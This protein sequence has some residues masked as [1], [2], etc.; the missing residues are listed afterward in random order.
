M[1]RR[2]FLATGAVST[3][4]M[5]FFPG[6]LLAEEAKSNNKL[7][8]PLPFKMDGEWKEFELYIDIHVHE[9]APGFK[10]H[11]L[12]F[13]D[14][15]PGPEIRVNAGDKVRVKF[16]NKTDLN[17]TIHWHGMHVPWRM[18]GV[19]FVTQL[20]VMPKNE[21][22]YEFEAQPEGTH[23]YHCHWGTLMHMQA[24]MFG[25]LIVEN[26]NDPI[27]KKFSYEREYTLVYS[28]HDTNYVRGEMNGMLERMKQQSFLM[29]EG[30]FTPEEWSVFDSKEQLQE[31]MSNGFI[32]PY[33]N[34]RRSMPDLPQANWFTV[35][36]KSY[37]STPYLFIKSGENI[38]VRL[39]N[40]GAEI[41]HLHLHGHDFWMVADDGIPIDNPWKRN[42]VALSPGKT[43]DIIIEGKNRGIWTFHDHDT[44][45]V[46]NNGLYP[47]GNL[48]ALVYEDLPADE[49]IISKH[50]GNP[51]YNSK[52]GMSGM[53]GMDA[54]KDGE[55]GN[56]NKMMFGQ[57]KLPKIAL[58]E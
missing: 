40:A 17:H 6:N 7:V 56:M 18:D 2:Y 37:P 4:G 32:P 3:A 47:G 25:S 28:A 10:Y 44:R 51:M 27:K 49:L 33:V 8:Q 13:N 42:T 38:R 23:F 12:A 54:M 20:P 19:P 24:G 11:T 35:N 5:V 48:L 50:S 9:P 58:D 39:I 15:I 29:K 16:I 46:T 55:K 36:G 14:M 43:Y 22:I 57:D 31:S 1:N 41:H 45:K 52:A 21:F 34:S 30:R 26:P 53:K